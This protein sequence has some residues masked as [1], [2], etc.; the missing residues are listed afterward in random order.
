[1]TGAAK[2]TDLTSIGNRLIQL[3]RALAAVDQDPSVRLSKQQQEIVRDRIYQAHRAYRELI[4]LG[5]A[6]LP[7]AHSEAIKQEY[8][9]IMNPVVQNFGGIQRQL[10][11]APKALN[12]LHDWNPTSTRSA[13]GPAA[14]PYRESAP[15]ELVRVKIPSTH[16]SWAKQRLDKLSTG[17]KVVT[18]AIASPFVVVFGSAAVV[19]YWSIYACEIATHRI[20]SKYSKQV[21]HLQMLMAFHGYIAAVLRLIQMADENN[22]EARSVLASTNT[23]KLA[24][25]MAKQ[26]WKDEHL[27]LIYTL[28]EKYGN[29]LAILTLYEKR[30]RNNNLPAGDLLRQIK[31][32]HGHIVDKI[33]AD[34]QSVGSLSP[35]ALRHVAKDYP[36]IAKIV[37][38]AGLEIAPL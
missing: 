30:H 22:A 13:S 23:E 8:T 25:R 19:A 4:T 12:Y 14:S 28:A 3:H 27:K 32:E 38:D 2:T 20:Q 7:E 16:L 33:R 34:Q 29:W 10:A 21:K 35:Y 18:I 5:S 11:R 9:N 37:I 26:G 31:D 24:N 36:N 17:K 15:R 6:E 1:M